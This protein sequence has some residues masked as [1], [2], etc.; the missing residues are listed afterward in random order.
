MVRLTCHTSKLKSDDCRLKNKPLGARMC[1]ACDHAAQEDALHV[2]MQCPARTASRTL[3]FENLQ[4]QYP[5]CTGMFTFGILMGGEIQD[6]AI[7]DMVEIWIISSGYIAGMYWQ[8][9]KDR[10]H[11][12]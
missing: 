1:S 2:I 8:V 9:L 4:E 11:E 10:R 7:H 6:V 5:E 12:A 3:L